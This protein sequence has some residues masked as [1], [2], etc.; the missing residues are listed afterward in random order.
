[1][2]S[3][4]NGATSLGPRLTAEWELAPF[5]GGKDQAGGCTLEAGPVTGRG[6]WLSLGGLCVCVEKH[7]ILGTAMSLV[8][9]INKRA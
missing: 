6:D 9:D 1:M 3:R 4:D 8:K 5:C 2:K 7:C